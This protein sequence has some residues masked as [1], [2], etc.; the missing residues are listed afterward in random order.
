M[1]IDISAEPATPP[2]QGVKV[3]VRKGKEKDEEKEDGIRTP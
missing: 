2:E 1:K 3:H